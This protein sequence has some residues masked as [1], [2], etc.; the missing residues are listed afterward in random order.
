VI[1][2]IFAINPKD[3]NIQAEKL[4]LIEWISRINDKSLISKLR[5]IQEEHIESEDWWNELNQAEKESIDR[6]LKD[7]E[8][9]RV[10]SHETVQKLYRKYL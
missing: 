3:M 5:R 10:H 7:I 8:E 4:S 6:G 9:G 2:T 1:I